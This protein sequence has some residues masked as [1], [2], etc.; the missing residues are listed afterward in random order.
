MRYLAGAFWLSVAWC[1]A[2]AECAYAQTP[3]KTLQ[4][5]VGVLTNCD[6]GAINSAINCEVRCTSSCPQGEVLGVFG[7]NL[8]TLEITY[9][10]SAGTGY[11][12]YLESCH[13]GYAATNC[14]DAAD[15][16]RVLGEVPSNGQLELKDGLVFRSSSATVYD[17]WSIGINYKRLRLRSIT[18]RGSPDA[19]DKITVRARLGV[20]PGL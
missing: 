3:P 10:R 13:E 19:N 17:A 16:S 7:Y 2:F 11:Q 18:G 20:S 5:D 9:T 15:W 8:L 6:A 1:V 14:T 4:T 12:F